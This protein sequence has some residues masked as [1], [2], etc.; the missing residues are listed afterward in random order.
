MPPQLIVRTN[1]L[2]RVADEFRLMLAERI[3][4]ERAAEAE[5]YKRQQDALKNSLDSRRVGVDEGRLGLDTTKWKDE[6]PKRI[7]DVAHTNAQ[8]AETSQRTTFAADDRARVIKGLSMLPAQGPPGR[9]S[10]RVLGELKAFGGVDFLTPSG[11]RATTTAQTLGTEAGQSDKAQFDA[12]GRDIE[13]ART[14]EQIRLERERARLRPTAGSGPSADILPLARM[15]AASPGVLQGVN[16]TMVGQVMNAIASD[17]TLRR[18]YDD[19]RMAPIRTNASNLLSAVDKLVSVGPSGKGALTPGAEA[20]FGEFTPASARGFIPGQNATDAYAALQ[21]VMG[22]QVLDLIGQM[23]EQSRTGATG[24]GALSTR[25]LDVLQSAATKLTNRL[26]H[27]GALEEL[28][29]IRN[30]LLKIG[31]DAP[32]STRSDGVIDASEWLRNRRGGR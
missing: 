7:A 22:R 26:S 32:G 19:T 9:V 1:P 11:E 3:Q 2:N 8:T 31:Q 5:A 29:S 24:F 21:Q 16:P 20:L 6:A 10:P 12:G 17:D 27:E 23:K 28:M 30:A 4:A 14:D 13:R 15:V 25:E 18:Q